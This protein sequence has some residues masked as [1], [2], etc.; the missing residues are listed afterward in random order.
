MKTRANLWLPAAATGPVQPVKHASKLTSCSG[1]FPSV[2][3]RPLPWLAFAAHHA[4]RHCEVVLDALRYNLNPA[5]GRR[6]I[7]SVLPNLLREFRDFNVWL[8]V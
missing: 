1:H 7:S 5:V 2:R 6:I 3:C 4:V 8:S